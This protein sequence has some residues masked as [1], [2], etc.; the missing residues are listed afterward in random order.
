MIAYFNGEFIPKEKVIISPDDRGFL[1][2]DGAY[3]V[4]RS[5]NGKLF[6]PDEH[7]ERMQRSLEEL[8]I[9]YSE[10]YKLKKVAEELIRIN[11][12]GEVQALIYIQITRGKALR[13]HSFPE[14]ETIPTVYVTASAFHYD[15]QK[16]VKGVKIILVPEMRWKRCD[17][18]SVAL[19]P[20]VL[21]RQQAK[22][23]GADEAVF[24]RDGVI[25][26]GTHTNFCAIFD[27]KLFTHPVNN[28]ILAGIT[29]KIVLDLCSK[30]NISV[31][32]SPIAET[33]LKE[34][35]ELMIVGTTVEIMPVVKV[36]DLK[37]GNRKPG[38][39]T[40]ELQRKFYLLLE[41]S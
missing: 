7:I 19:L 33:K 17:I 13:T 30:M 16:L 28:H 26:E 31:V 1:F 23:N 14:E 11:T 39:I 41:Q 12:L 29:R 27:G 4:I 24:V 5:Y 18:K 36:D 34:A 32:E 10:I 35:D 15:P 8:R 37:I 25:T 3:E 21:A 6:K 22:D 9:K 40:L 20:N 2:A 38:P